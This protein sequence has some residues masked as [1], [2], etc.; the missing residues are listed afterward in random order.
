MPATTN[1]MRVLYF[2][3][4]IIS[5]R[6]ATDQEVQSF[7]DY[8]NKKAKERSSFVATNSKDILQKYD[9]FREGYVFRQYEIYLDRYHVQ[10]KKAEESFIGY[11]T[12]LKEIHE[13]RCTCEG[14]LHEVSGMFGQFISCK[15][16]RDTTKEH[17]KLSKPVVFESEPK[18]YIDFERDFT[19]PKTFLNEFVNEHYPKKAK[20]SDFYELIKMNNR[21]TYSLDDE[22]FYRVVDVNRKSKHREKM[23]EQ[24]AM[25]K[26]TKYQAQKWISV[27]YSNEKM[28]KLKR[29]DLVA[30]IDSNT[31][32]VFEQKKNYQNIDQDQLQEYVNL[33]TL[34][35][36]NYTVKGYFI[37]EE[38][39]GEQL[40]ENV[41]TF[42]TFEDEFN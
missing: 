20:L 39:D 34:C 13:Y 22:Y 33:V 7:Y 6:W 38:H 31:I 8:Q 18:E 10:H 16:W 4:K 5:A 27:Q 1:L 12:L 41:L 30:V 42:E 32:G 14:E 9:F 23:V 29:V 25:T 26:F 35:A 37:I 11:N 28:R 24:L 19:W 3:T 21:P 15:N 36:P 17:V 2:M 40:P